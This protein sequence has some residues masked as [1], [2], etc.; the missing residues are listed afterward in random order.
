MLTR[1][2]KILL[3]LLAVQVLLVILVLTHGDDSAALKAHPIL[4][5][6]D[7]AKVTRLQVFAGQDAKPIDIVKRDAGWVL[8]SSF[9]YPVEPSKVT[10]VLSPIA[11][12]TAAAPLA[13]QAG[14]HKQ[15]KVADTEFERKLV[16]TQDGKDTTLYIGG[17]AGLRRVAFRVGGSDNVFGVTGISAGPIGSEPRMWVDHGY[18]KVPREDI[19]KVVVERDGKSMELAR[20]IPPA[21]PSAG[22][23]SDAGSAAPPAPPAAD[24]WNVSVA[25]A[26]VT[27][28][29]GE[30]LDEAMIDRLVGDAGTLELTAPADPKR[31][32]SKPTAT[33]TIERK[34]SGTT[35]PAATVVDVIADGAS[36]WVHDRSSPRA[37]LV[38]KARLEGL[39]T[40]DRDK[41]VKKPPPPPPPSP[42]PGAGSGSPTHPGLAAPF[43]PGA[44]AIPPGAIPPPH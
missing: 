14:R 37:V 36:Y 17:S 25:G 24:H 28:A 12:L 16:I 5:G 6:F 27:L 8:A 22:S 38:D 31:D 2:H 19:A 44:G 18:V 39:L 11:K 13:T 7:A 29:A 30:S 41:L 15:L 26:P 1:F 23:G 21:L 10:D 20:I 42:A 34:A 3:G 32:A 35:T 43:R 4:T 33:I 40:A 9:D